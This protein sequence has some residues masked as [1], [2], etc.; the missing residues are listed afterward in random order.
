MTSQAAIETVQ[1]NSAA[2]SRRDVEGMLSFYAL[3]AVVVDRRPHGYGEYRGHAA[4]RAYYEGIVDNAAELRE[5]LEILDASDARVVVHA[6]FWARLAASDA[7][8]GDV[9]LN[10][11]MVMGLRDG[12]IATL[13]VYPDG[14]SA[15]AAANRSR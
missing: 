7:G 8:A 4:L 15:L 13:D 5:E 9:T 10:Y 6:K 14:M 2:F 1:G 12:L 3:D 11:G